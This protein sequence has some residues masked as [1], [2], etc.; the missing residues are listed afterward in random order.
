MAEQREGGLWQGIRKNKAR[1]IRW[2]GISRVV[3]EESGVF[4][5]EYLQIKQP[6]SVLQSAADVG[7][8][9]WK[10]PLGRCNVGMGLAFAFSYLN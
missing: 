9:L 5:D 7:G 10:M 4:A 8:N 2:G 3:M 6:V 1:W